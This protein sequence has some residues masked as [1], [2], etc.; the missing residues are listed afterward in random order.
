M[1]IFKL[2]HGM[3]KIIVN[4]KQ[5]W[6]DYRVVIGDNLIKFYELDDDD[7]YDLTIWSAPHPFPSGVRL[8]RYDQQE[9]DQV[10]LVFIPAE[11]LLQTEEIEL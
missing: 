4:T 11:I 6:C 9:K 3:Y 8:L 7:G 2:P 10:V 1:N 5:R